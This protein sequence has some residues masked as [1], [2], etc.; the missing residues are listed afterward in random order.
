MHP[1]FRPISVA[2]LFWCFGNSFPLPSQAATANLSGTISDPSGAAVS[3]AQLVAEPLDNPSAASV[4]AVSGTEGRYNLDLPSGRYRLRVLRESF[5]AREFVVALA[6]G[7]SKALNIRLEL[8][9][10]SSS[11]VV[12]AQAEPLDVNQSPAPATIISREEIEQRQAV[13]LPDLLA[14][15]PGMSLART[16]AEGGLATLFLDGGNS[17]F[18]KVLVDGTPVNEPGGFFNLSNLTLDDVDKVE[19]VQGAESAIYGTDAV[20]GVIQIFT[21]RGETHSPELSVFG[22]GGSFSTGRG[23][24]QVSGLLGNFDYSASAAYLETSGQGP[25]DAFLDRNFNG[26]FGWRFSDDDRLRLALLNASS[27]AGIPGPT[28]PPLS[29]APNLVQTDSLHILSANLNWTFRTGSHWEHEL[30]GTES[31][32]HDDNNDP[33]SFTAIDDFNRAGVQAQ[34][35]YVSRKVSATA[36]YAYEV[37]NGFPSLLNGQHAWRDNHAGFLDARWQATSRLILSAGARADANSG[38]GTRVVPRVGAAYA[39]RYGSGLWGDTRLHAFYGQGIKEPT[40]DELFSSDPCFPGVP[41]LS[42]ERSRTFGAGLE[43]H[44]AS[45]RLRLSADYFDNRFYDMV[46]LAYGPAT[47][48]CTFGTGTY[49][50]SDLARARG[51][52]FTA[53]SHLRRWLALVGSYTYDDTRLVKSLNPFDDPALAPGN[54]LLRRPV[55]SGSLVMNAA[56]RRMNWNLAGYFCGP[57]TDSDFVHPNLI[58]NPGYARFDLATS[59][60][61]RRGIMLYGRVTNLFNKQYEDALG[62]PALGRDFRLGMKYTRRPKE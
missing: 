51:V 4:R 55:N 45:D 48:T 30:M 12:T 44:L 62:Y 37:E 29:L 9:P 21:H 31:R 50:N 10:L 11:V 1:A 34:S 3:G 23:G 28:G 27:D 13:S 16:G 5:S 17:N 61:L 58:N 32:T 38:F 14:T 15:Q 60:D 22:E 46:T 20:S 42:P 26:S 39:L 35:T 56:F 40:M 33:G 19:I 49:I 36:G 47:L 25:N 52:N 18:T 6:P 2:F 24:A 59:Y 53:Q 41:S 54:H 57:R 43:Q 8:E 7:E